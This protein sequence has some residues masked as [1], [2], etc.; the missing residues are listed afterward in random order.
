MDHTGMNVIDLSKYPEDVRLVIGKVCQLW[1]LKP[2][3]GKSRGY[4]I[5]GSRALGDACG[6]FGLDLLDEIHGE[7]LYQ[8]ERNQGIPKWTVEGPQS[9][10]KTARAL[11]GRK[12]QAG[13]ISEGSNRPIS[14]DDWYRVMARR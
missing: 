4:W 3:Q 9:L 5:E 6:E 7:W 11:A 12:R 14:S 2:P 10:E 8:M 1:K 13:N